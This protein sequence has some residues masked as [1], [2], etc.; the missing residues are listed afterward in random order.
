[1]TANET[2]KEL[3]LKYLENFDLSTPGQR[4]EGLRWRVKEAITEAVAEERD[5]LVAEANARAKQ[6]TDKD[7]RWGAGYTC[8]MQQFAAA[9]RE[10]EK[11]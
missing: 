8:A 7:D 1:M 11:P 6:Y 4:Y 2:A 5:K 3:A 10:R 9:I